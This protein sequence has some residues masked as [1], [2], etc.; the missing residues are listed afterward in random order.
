[1]RRPD[2]TRAEQL[3]GWSPQV[4]SEDGLRR[5]VA[6]FASVLRAPVAAAG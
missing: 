6:W 2:T 5:T 4:T 3:L 1:V